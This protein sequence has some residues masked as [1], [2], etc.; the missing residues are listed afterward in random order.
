MVDMRGKQFECVDQQAPAE[1]VL[2]D[3]RIE[4]VLR[5][6]AERYDSPKATKATAQARQFK[7]SDVRSVRPSEVFAAS[8]DHSPQGV[9]IARRP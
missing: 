9:P 5:G 3:P 2:I 6:K 4:Y 1:G 7:S 8:C